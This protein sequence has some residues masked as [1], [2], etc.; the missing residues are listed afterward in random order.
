MKMLLAA[1]LLIALALYILD[2]RA[3]AP[4]VVTEAAATPVPDRIVAPPVKRVAGEGAAS[5]VGSVN[6]KEQGPTPEPKSG[7]WMF[8][9]YKPALN[10]KAQR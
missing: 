1:A 2:K 5:R 3:A 8:K 9:N 6:A 4:P 10:Q 7:D